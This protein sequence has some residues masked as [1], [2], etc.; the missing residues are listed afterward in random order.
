MPLSVSFHQRCTLFSIY[1]LLL[2][3]GQRAKPVNLP[4]SN[5]LSEV[6]E[7]WIEITFALCLKR[8]IASR[9]VT[10]LRRWTLRR[11]W[12]APPV[13]PAPS[14]TTAANCAILSDSYVL[15]RS[16]ISERKADSFR[17]DAVFWFYCRRLRYM[18]KSFRRKIELTLRPR[19]N[20]C[21]LLASY[22]VSHVV[23][24]R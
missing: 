22:D 9:H 3:E 7:Y 6:G 20:S 16:V 17:N 8:S 18:G 10:S 12:P 1:T 11:Q 21:A 19:G 14:P 13:P 2:P 5:A 24:R 15:R 23:P 4:K